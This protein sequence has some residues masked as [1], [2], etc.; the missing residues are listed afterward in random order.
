MKSILACDIVMLE[1]THVSLGGFGGRHVHI[2][3]RYRD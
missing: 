3:V 1:R 2:V